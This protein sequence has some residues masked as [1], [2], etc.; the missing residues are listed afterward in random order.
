MKSTQYYPVLMTDRVADT[1]RYYEQHFRFTRLFDSNWYVHLQSL[2][3][4]SVNLA[5]LDGDHATI[6]EAARGGRAAGVLLN[7]EV[8]DAS[9]EYQRVLDQGLDVQLA[10]RDEAFGQRHFIVKDPNGVLIDVIQPI[11]P[12][13]TYLAQYAAG[14]AAT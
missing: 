14:A 5:I 12:D 3:D 4:A 2:E 8:E 10:L 6:P 13:A 1:A 11:A 9:A 7:F